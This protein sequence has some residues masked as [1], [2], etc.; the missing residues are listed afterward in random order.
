MNTNFL[1]WCR[2]LFPILACLSIACTETPPPDEEEIVAR[3]GRETIGKSE[4]EEFAAM[5]L[6]GLRPDKS[7]REGRLEYL[8]S[9]IDEKLL[10]LEARA[11]GLDTTRA[12]KTNLQKRFST[13]VVGYYRT[14]HLYPRIDVTE[15]EVRDRFIQ[16][17]LNR[18]R[19]LW[20]LVVATVEEAEQLRE[21]TD[22]QGANFADLAK[23]HTLEKSRAAEGGYLGFVHA[24]TAARLQVPRQVFN[25]LPPGEVS[26]PVPLRNFYQLILF[27]EE[28]AGDLHA[29]RDRIMGRLGQEKLALLTQ[30]TTEELASELDLAIRS[31][32]LKILLEK[33][34]EMGSRRYPQLSPPEAATPL[35]TY[36]GGE[37]TVGEYI[38]HFRTGG[39]RLVLEGKSEVDRAARRRVLPGFML[40]EAARRQGYHELKP[41][42]EWKERETIDQLITAL[43]QRVLDEQVVVTDE[44]AEQF[45]RDN[46]SFFIEPE[47][48]EI[49]EILVDDEEQAI[50]LRQRLDA[51]EEMDALVHLSRHPEA[52]KDRGKRHLHP[53]EGSE[54]ARHA[55]AAQEGQLLGPIQTGHG[56]SVFRVLN[57]SGGRLLPFPEAAQAATAHVRYRLETRVFNELLAAL[58][59]KYADRVQI[60]EEVLSAVQ[61]PAKDALPPQVQRRRRDKLYLLGARYFEE[62]RYD[63]VV[64]V[65]QE[66]LQMDSLLVEVRCNLGIAYQKLGRLDEAVAA[67]QSAIRIDSTYL[68]AYHNLAQTYVE[69]GDF[70]SAFSELD[71]ALRIE[72]ESADTYLLLAFFYSA[73]GRFDREDEALSKAVAVDPENAKAWQ[74]LGSAYRK[75]GRSEPAEAALLRAVEL[76]PNSEEAW[77]E[78]GGLYSDAGRYDEADRAIQRALDIDP[79]YAEA[80]FNL[81]QL[82]SAQGKT[83]EAQTM[84]ERFESLPPRTDQMTTK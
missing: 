13:Y 68:R 82:R 29:G 17:G 34:K 78:L 58:R 15:A 24:G 69:Q 55:F 60:F 74:V 31:E 28:R 30:A 72:P 54:M 73:Q 43:R 32:G 26:Q 67:Y 83:E 39:G 14:R 77:N 56:H 51:G 25:T 80:Y 79:D 63:K 38:D 48:V 19:A 81:A 5:L 57:K 59:E 12:F 8:Q 35:Y 9:L 66:L 75:L 42:L 53:W 71:A 22:G 44:Q 65:A 36:E 40:W 7:G 21:E 50:Q 23:A 16:N 45:Y 76:D 11:R 46:P 27:G 49:Q 33:K 84:L 62:A 52:G 61:L 10:V 3:M 4:L 2:T 47:E 41:M 64:E 6:P 1:P 20:R 18:E 37:I 70:P